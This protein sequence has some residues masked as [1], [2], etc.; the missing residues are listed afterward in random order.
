MI[1]IKTIKE[2]G[3]KYSI[4][5]YGYEIYKKLFVFIIKLFYKGKD[6]TTFSQ[7]A[8][9]LF[10]DILIGYKKKGLYIDIGAC[11]PVILSNTKKFYDRGWEGLNIEPNPKNYKLFL[12]QRSK[13]VN[14]N[15]GI[16]EKDETL[17]FYE[18]DTDT[19][20][21]FSK[22]RVEKLKEEGF[23]L[24]E[25]IEIK[26]LPLW[27]VFEGVKGQVDFMSIDT[28]GLDM[29]VIKSNNWNKYRPK[30]ICIEGNNYDDF[31]KEVGY[32]KVIFNGLNSF[33]TDITRNRK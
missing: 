8:E 22:E 32:K 13:D 30:I 11:H 24:L 16:G 23:K 10:I 21:T 28:E 26:V 29:K 4:H 2:K 33:F 14:L 9:D 31:F 20:S 6:K 7:Y 5:A 1:Y 25:E 17:T 19:V 18:F 27:K 15:I 12:Y 3:L